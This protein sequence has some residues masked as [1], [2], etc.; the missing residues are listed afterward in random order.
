MRVVASDATSRQWPVTLPT[1]RTR[2]ASPAAPLGATW[3][4]NSAC[5]YQEVSRRQ[6]MG[7]PMPR[8]STPQPST[9]QRMPTPVRPTPSAT[10]SASACRRPLPARGRST[11]WTRSSTPIAVP[12]TART[13]D[14]S[15]ARSRGGAPQV[16]DGALDSEVTVGSAQLVSEV[17]EQLLALGHLHLGLDALAPHPV[18][19]PQDTAALLGLSHHHLDRVGG[20]AVHAADLGYGADRREHVEGE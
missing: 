2:T 17:T 12:T 20:G 1:R 19:H 3:P 4:T 6:E 8:S 14:R 5:R 15:S 10:G 18:D 16:V 7:W 9:V 13:G 11:V